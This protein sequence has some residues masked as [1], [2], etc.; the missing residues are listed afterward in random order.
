MFITFCFKLE[1]YGIDRYIIHTIEYNI[2]FPPNAFIFSFIPN[3]N[4]A[5][6]NYIFSPGTEY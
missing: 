5:S 2:L 1:E 6:G 4:L 3:F